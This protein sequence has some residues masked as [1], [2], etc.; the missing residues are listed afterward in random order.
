MTDVR[1][2]A[3]PAATAEKRANSDSG[4]IWYELMT[5]DADGAKAFYDAVVGWNIDAQSSFPNGYRLI[6]RSDG[7]SAGGVL[8][9]TQ[10]MQQHGARPTWLGYLHV[11]DVDA[12]VKAIE[13]DGG[14][15]LMPAF[16]IPNVGRVAMVADPQGAAF[17]IMKPIPPAG[18]PEAASDVFS[19]TE[20]QRCAWNELLTTDLDAAKRFYPKHFGWKLGDTMPMG[21][22]GDYQFIDQGGRMIGAMFAPQDRPPAWRFCFRVDNLEKSIEAIGSGGGEILFGP[23]EVPG[24]G[25]IVQA[26]DP[27]GAFFMVIEG[28]NQ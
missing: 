27:Q 24:G 22:M 25:R 9:L 6:G 12:S 2:E 1:D 28:G 10:E 13:K 26:N 8:P 20:V 3:A 21:P 23:T 17:Y 4:F 14:R 18:Q 15:A 11:D 5:P 7:K 16:D 19:P